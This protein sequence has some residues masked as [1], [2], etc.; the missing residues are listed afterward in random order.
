MTIQ[1]FIDKVQGG[2]IVSCQALADEPLHG[3]FIMSRMALAAEQGGAVG[4]RAN[5]A[6]DI[7]SIHQ[8]VR[9][10]IIG[11]EKDGN[12]GV[13]ITPT[14]AHAQRIAEAGASVIALDATLRPR[15]DSNTLDDLIER[16]H[17]K[18]NLPVMA[19]VSTLEE[20]FK[21]QALGADIIGTTLAG[22]TPYSRQL[23][24]PDWELLQAMV[25]QLSVPIIAEGRIHT[26]EHARQALQL[27]AVAVVVGGAITRPQQITT[28]FVNE[29]KS[30]NG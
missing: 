5:G 28:R 22:Y 7:F 27:G 29:I 3:A 8:T 20:A 30:I 24:D 14:F 1:A 19:D 15:P 18:L 4:I 16:I 10:P 13:Y 11:I 2:L 21:A 17:N 9:L 25:K 6:D 23:T 26:P 12:E